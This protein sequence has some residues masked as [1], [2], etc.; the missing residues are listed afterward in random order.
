MFAICRRSLFYIYYIISDAFRNSSN[1]DDNPM[2]KE[3][4]R[5]IEFEYT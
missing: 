1:S 2:D 3:T 4:V 5:A